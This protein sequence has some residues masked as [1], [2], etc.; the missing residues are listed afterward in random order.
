MLVIMVYIIS[1]TL[2]DNNSKQFASR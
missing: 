2:R 1:L